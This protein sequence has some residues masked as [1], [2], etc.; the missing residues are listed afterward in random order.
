VEGRKAEVG[1]GG[2]GVKSGLKGNTFVLTYYPLDHP[3]CYT[4]TTHTTLIMRYC[5]QK[6]LIFALGRP[7]V[8]PLDDLGFVEGVREAYQLSE[9]P[10]RKEV[11]ERG[12]LWRPYRTFATWYM[13]AIR[14]LQQ[15]NARERTRIV[16]L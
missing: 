10:S 12:E 4:F 13:W 3:L 2:N 11:L 8:L 9:R 5:V 16:S 1:E 15:K 6:F 14:R 7:D